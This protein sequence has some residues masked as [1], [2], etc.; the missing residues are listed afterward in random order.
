MIARKLAHLAGEMH[1][2]IGQ[3]DFR[4]ADATGIENDLAGRRIAGV[5]S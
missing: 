5:V 1:A 4:F 3:Q 2:A